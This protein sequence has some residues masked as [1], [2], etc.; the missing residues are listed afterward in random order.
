M[1]FTLT[2][3]LTS[4]KNGRQL[5]PLRKVYNS[6]TIS[7][8]HG[9]FVQ[10]T[11]SFCLIFTIHGQS[12]ICQNF[13]QFKDNFAHEL[14]KIRNNVGWSEKVI[15]IFIKCLWIVQFLNQLPKMYNSWTFMTS[16]INCQD[17]LKSKSGP[18]GGSPIYSKGSLYIGLPGGGP[19]FKTTDQL[20]GSAKIKIWTPGG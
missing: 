19:D 13:V 7:T 4:P 14:Y 2:L 11:D 5:P 9:R 16:S 1:T 12:E 17:P 20:P 15:F 3:T 6:W 8:I 10:F 18:P